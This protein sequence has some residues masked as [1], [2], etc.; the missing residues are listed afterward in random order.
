MIQKSAGSFGLKLHVSFFDTRPNILLYFA[1]LA[2]STLLENRDNE[3]H[4]A[5]GVFVI[6]SVD[7]LVNHY[8]W[9]WRG[10]V[11]LNK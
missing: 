3:A 7:A 10:Y 4:K 9:S 2:L 6:L 5:L 11:Q 8:F 1:E